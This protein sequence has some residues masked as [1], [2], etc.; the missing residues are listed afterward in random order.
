MIYI[1]KY[2]FIYLNV[3]VYVVQFNILECKFIN[4]TFIK[5][6]IIY[7]C[8]LFQKNALSL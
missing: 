1:Y 5:Q 7:K 8:C 4:L 6:N 2:T 3:N